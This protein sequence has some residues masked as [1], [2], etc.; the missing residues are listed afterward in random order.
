M[1]IVDQNV[2]KRTG[3]PSFKEGGGTSIAV[4]TSCA[5]CN[6]ELF[7]G[8]Q[9]GDATDWPVGRVI[10]GVLLYCSECQRILDELSE[11]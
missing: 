10:E 6:T 3:F 8:N 4:W 1:T 7:Y 5:G 2:I 11:E 9:D